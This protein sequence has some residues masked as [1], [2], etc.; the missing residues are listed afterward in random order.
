MDTIFPLLHFFNLNFW[1]K[2]SEKFGI[3]LLSFKNIFHR[4]WIC[5]QNLE[6]HSPVINTMWTLKPKPPPTSPTILSPPFFWWRLQR[7]NGIW[8][9]KRPSWIISKPWSFSGYYGW[10]AGSMKKLL[11]CLPRIPEPSAPHRKYCKLHCSKWIFKSSLLTCF[12]LV[13]F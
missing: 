1:I 13:L 9:V 6:G 8:L 4:K 3:S 11:L 2:L 7:S 10:V 12:F 5:N